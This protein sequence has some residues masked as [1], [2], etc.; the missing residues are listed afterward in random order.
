MAKKKLN[1]KVAIAGS[2]VLALF[3]LAAIFYLLYK[4]QGPQKFVEDGDAAVVKK[5]YETALKQYGRALSRAKKDNALQEKIL[6]KLADIHVVRGDTRKALACWSKVATID[7]SDKTSRTKL[8]D[9]YYEMAN[10][11]QSPVWKTVLT[12]VDELLPLASEAKFYLIK[13]RAK[14]E[15]AKGGEVVDKVQ[16]FNEAIDILKKAQELAPSNPN[17][18][19]YLAEAVEAK[20]IA[21][22]QKGSS[23]EKNKAH[24][25]AIKLLEKA[26]SVA[27][28][29]PNAYLQLLGTKL[30][31]AQNAEQV[32]QLEADYIALTKKFSKSSDVFSTLSSYYLYY[33][34]NKP[35]VHTIDKAL[36]AA[37]KA[38]ELSPQS[39]KYALSA[40]DMYYRKGSLAKD[41]TYLQK[42]VETAKKGL[43]LPDACDTRG[44]REYANKMNKLSLNTF[45]AYR[46][47][48]RIFVL[49]TDAS[50]QQNALVA[51][52][53]QAVHELAQI[54][55][56]GENPYVVATTGMLTYVK[57]NTA[58]G[59]RK[60]YAAYQQLKQSDT[61]YQ[62]VQLAQL[63]Y[64]LAKVFA[65]SSEIGATREFLFNALQRKIHLAKPEALLLYAQISLQLRQYS[66]A[67]NALDMYEKL[68][69]PNATSQLLRAEATI[70]A[71]QFDDAQ[72]LLAKIKSDDPNI[73]T[74]KMSLLQTRIEQA[75][76]A[77]RDANDTK[78]ANVDEYRN[79]QV[80][81]AQ[82]LL[83]SDPNT[84][85]ALAVVCENY[86]A[87]N[88][89][90]EAKTLVNGIL[91]RAPDNT[92]AAFYK[93]L[94]AEP[95]PAKVT[96]QRRAD[97]AEQATAAIRDPA[98]RAL[99]L[100]ERYRSKE[101]YDK[102]ISEYK[103]AIEASPADKAA[104]N[105]LFESALQTKDFTL[106]EQFAAVAKRENID[107]C[108]GQ[109][110]M[111]RL[112][113]AKKD[114]KD[115]LSRLDTVLKERP[116]YSFATMLRSSV[117]A[118]LGNEQPAIEDARKAVDLNPL[119]SIAAKNF[120]SML[121]QR[122]LKL[123]QKISK[124]QTTEMREAIKRAWLLNQRDWQLLS[125]YAEYIK[126]TD[127]LQALSIHQQLQSAV[128]NAQN[129]TLLG[130]LAAKLASEQTDTEKQKA[131]FAMAASAYEQGYKI[132]PNNA[133][134][135]RSYAKFLSLTGKSSQADQLLNK[136]TNKNLLW[137][138]QIQ[139][140]QF[141]QAKE[142]LDTLYKE[143]PKNIDILKGQILTA[144]NLGDAQGVLRYSQELLSFENTPE[145]QLA[146]IESCLR[147]GLIEQAG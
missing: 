2:I 123:G 54:W 138:H 95:N 66:D 39:A 51:E 60:M 114:Y 40:A 78:D 115:A 147:V 25:Q 128:P 30:L 103:K 124:E 105:G 125:F 134:L 41:D 73:L 24:K 34:M 77:H 104:I 99:M 32:E 88:K 9:F 17:G 141:E 43:T 3:A 127:P 145:T 65:N 28:T 79:E 74:I 143:N 59:I 63:S 10:A 56:T 35:N 109:L 11:G 140:G 120:A 117:Q 90:P 133:A 139:M 126:D 129:A 87:K 29:D 93:L 116:V 67:I 107:L 91:T 76:A 4:M 15:L 144:Q 142:V 49:P 64:M 45:I 89:L 80:M 18:Y 62:D 20:G 8:L 50:K 72:T 71:G 61:N 46:S 111:A 58:E 16:A 38:M 6:F 97:L 68:L 31:A 48:E 135:L 136:A 132:D 23:D 1:K 81:L 119:D 146:Q 14:L 53:E 84:T 21:L 26:M 130:N 92:I 102:A 110:F 113:I 100:A 22:A 83:R 47:I 75:S 7:T 36:A 70:G 55:G 131:Y 5:D 33:Y 106:A 12:T 108:G 19:R 82:K 122:N 112:A 69:G 98:K 101:L 27:P 118:E 44:P 13:G 57:G 42:A 85:Q 137:V 96:P 121:Y 37:Q 52:A 94:L 86:I